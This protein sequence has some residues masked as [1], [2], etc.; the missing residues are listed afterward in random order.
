MRRRRGAATAFYES[1]SS[2]S[3][4]SVTRREELSKE[5]IEFALFARGFFIMFHIAF[6]CMR[7]GLA[8]LRP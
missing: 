4:D 3:V 7:P 6:E 5:A 8:C 1:A 2:N